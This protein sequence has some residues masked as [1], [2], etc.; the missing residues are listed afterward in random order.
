MFMS[1]PPGFE[2]MGQD[3][4][5]RLKKSLYGLKQSPRAWFERFGK[6]VKS[7]GYH[8]SQA[9]N[10]MFY[11]RSEKGKISILIV[12]INDIILTGDD[13]EELVNIK[14]KL[15][16]DFEIKDLGLL[17]YFLG[18]EFA[19]SRKG[20]FVNQRKYIL[21]LLS[22]TGLLGCKAAD[23]PLDAN[24]KL[25][26]AKAK[27]VIDKEKFQRLVGKLIYLSHTRPDIAFAV[28]MVSQY[29]H[30]P[31][32][33][34]FNATYRILRYL[35]GTPGKGLMF[36]KNNNLQIEVYTDAD[37]VGCTTDRR[38]TSG[39]CTFIGGN[40]VTWRSKKQNVVARSSVEVEFRSLAHGISEAI[41]LKRLFE[42][43][44]ISVSY[45]MKVYCDNK[46]AI[47]ITH[48][49]VLHDRTKHIEVDKHFIKE[50]IES[51]LICLSYVPTTDQIADILTK[52][53]H[54]GQFELLVSKLA[55][56]NIFKPA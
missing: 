3:K 18:M 16:R 7:H 24:L 47:S 53:L 20:I 33:E 32:R 46:A 36:R 17:K 4:V 43:L 2:M 56:E 5:C 1:P 45:P 21:D 23:S 8:Q 10:T 34:H 22:E 48:N 26:P 55:M 35:K 40:L 39:Y 27:D 31:G 54:K 42:D 38:S 12:Y 37:W 25:D 19:R 9:D 41:W 6:A 29:M 30:S 44:K 15:A 14:K 52:G 51:G 11:K 49:P 28:S 50:K 13:S